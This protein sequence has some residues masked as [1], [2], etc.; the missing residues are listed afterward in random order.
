MTF[1]TPS[2]LH[3]I[4]T[5][6]SLS[7]AQTASLLGLSLSYYRKL[8]QGNRTTPGL[9]VSQRISKFFQATVEDVFGQNIT[10]ERLDE[11]AEAW[12]TERA[13]QIRERKNTASVSQMA[14]PA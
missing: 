4:R 12:H 7:Q 10:Q 2:N 14:I 3:K 1:S 5:M 8:D 13:R 9:D 11:I 6:T